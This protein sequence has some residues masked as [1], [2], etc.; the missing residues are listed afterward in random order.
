MTATGRHPVLLALVAVLALAGAACGSDGDAVADG[1]GSTTVAGDVGGAG[2]GAASSEAGAAGHITV[3]A[4]ASLTDV[5]GD[6]G[7]A[8][9]A[10]HPG[11]TV[12]LS[13]GP[14][15]GLVTQVTEG[16][17][18]D[19]VATASRATMDDLV[20]ADALDGDPQP[21]ATN[22]LELAVPPGNPGEVDD[23][24]DLADDD[25]VVALC[26]EEV[27]CGSFAR[28]ALDRAGV[29]PSVD[30]DEQDVRALLTKVEADEVD[31]GIVY[32]TDVVAAGD[33][34]EGIAIPAEQNVEATY[35]IAV[36][37]QAGDVQTARA[38]IDFVL[39]D[40][41]Q[42]VLADAGFGPP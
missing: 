20:E 2:A 12:D 18:A 23:L 39:S 15:S 26:A 22:A 17:P 3:F 11:A 27:P 13:F 37:G 9:E 21:F 36:P 35:P 29:E 24:S 28:E 7:D 40:D 1:T 38:F 16:A 4:A 10:A 34:V 42:D 8:F 32:A 33:G 25:L 6:L 31:V 5:F 30:S 14:S 41:G 19:V